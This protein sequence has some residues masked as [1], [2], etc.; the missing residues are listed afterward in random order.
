[1]AL[2]DWLLRE[3]RRG[4]DISGLIIGVSYVTVLKICEKW[5]ATLHFLSMLYTNKLYVWSLMYKAL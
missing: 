4:Y 2:N 1:M 3:S 5:Y